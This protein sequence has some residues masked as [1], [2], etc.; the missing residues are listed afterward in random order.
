[1]TRVTVLSTK[2]V[3]DQVTGSRIARAEYSLVRRPGRSAGLSIS[4]GICGRRENR[5]RAADFG[6]TGAGAQHRPIRAHYRGPGP[7]ALQP[8]GQF[9]AGMSRHDDGAPASH[10]VM[11][12]RVK[13]SG[14]DEG[15]PGADHRVQSF[16][17][18]EYRIGA[19]PARQ[20]PSSA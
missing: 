12:G 11:L 15:E 14:R 13:R 8:E 5:Y 20:L 1:M 6:Q 9:R 2:S 19:Q 4:D 10:L 16:A 3:I 17:I 7:T 18:D